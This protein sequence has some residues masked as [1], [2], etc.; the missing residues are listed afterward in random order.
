METKYAIRCSTEE[1]YN[2]A[3]NHPER[4]VIIYDE[5]Q[6]DIKSSSD[7][8]T[9]ITYAEAL[10]KGLLGERVI[11]DNTIKSIHIPPTTE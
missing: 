7:I 2:E 10:E 5:Q 6:R 1:E 9:I 8:Y 4:Y 3:K 11:V